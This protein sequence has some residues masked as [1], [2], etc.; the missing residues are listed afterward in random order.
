MVR[1]KRRRKRS[2]DFDPITPEVEEL[3]EWIACQLFNLV[4]EGVK[5]LFPGKPPEDKKE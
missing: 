4:L 2:F 5:W 3:L 1:R